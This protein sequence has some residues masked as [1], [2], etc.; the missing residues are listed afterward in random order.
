VIRSFVVATGA[1]STIAGQ[2]G[3]RGTDDGPA[4]NARFSAP[5]GLALDGAGNLYVADSGNHAIRRIEIASATVTTYAGVLGQHG[6]AVG[7]I[8]GRLNR[9]SGLA[10]LPDGGLA[11][12]DEQA[13]LVV[14]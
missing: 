4:A 10:V 3:T 2:V 7:A 9:P 1:L 8:P 12:L 11:I 13:V 14:R 5:E 6:V